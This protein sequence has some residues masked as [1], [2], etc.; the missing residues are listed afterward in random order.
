MIIKK[1]FIGIFLFF[2]SLSTVKISYAKAVQKLDLTGYLPSRNLYSNW[3][4][5]NI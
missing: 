4:D 1:S 2:L 3:E 5:R